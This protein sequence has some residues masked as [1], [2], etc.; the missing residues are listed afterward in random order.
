MNDES[1]VEIHFFPAMGPVMQARPSPVAGGFVHLKKTDGSVLLRDTE[2]PYSCPWCDC[3]SADRD[4]R[5]EEVVNKFSAS[6]P[7][8]WRHQHVL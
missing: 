1:A 4:A 5:I 7:S 6:I 2:G 3:G 8:D